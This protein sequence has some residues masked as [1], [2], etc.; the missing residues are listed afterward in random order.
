MS[1]NLA[2]ASQ[3]TFT[4]Q[5]Y[6]KHSVEI[7]NL[8]EQIGILTDFIIDLQ[9]K[10]EKLEEKK[11]RFYHPLFFYLSALPLSY[12]FYRHISINKL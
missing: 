8:K 9:K 3:V 5:S 10:V 12:L 1:I 2:H 7:K 6:I 4:N 11:K